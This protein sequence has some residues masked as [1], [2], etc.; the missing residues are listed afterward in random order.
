LKS[1]SVESFIERGLHSCK[2]KYSFEF[3]CCECF[4]WLAI[5]DTILNN[6]RVFDRKGTFLY[7]TKQL[8]ELPFK[9]KRMDTCSY[10]HP[11]D[12]ELASVI[13]MKMS[14]PVISSAT[15]SSSLHHHHSSNR[16]SIMQL[17]QQH[18]PKSD[19]GNAVAK[20]LQGYDWSLVPLAS[21]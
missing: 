4:N 15:A 13:K 17:A 18:L 20:V 11:S 19:I 12:A 2:T 3:E 21:R 6:G 8:V 16:A 5:D 10:Q 14:L 9:K 1:F 7:T